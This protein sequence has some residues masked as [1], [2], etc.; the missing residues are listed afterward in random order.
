MFLTDLFLFCLGSQGSFLNC[1]Y[2]WPKSEA[3]CSF[4]IVLIRKKV[5]VM[6]TY[7]DCDVSA[8]H[9]FRERLGGAI[10]LNHTLSVPHFVFFPS[11]SL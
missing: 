6:S 2:F 7:Q 10:I 11:F 1:S 5:C 3:Q 9:V 8:P 4:K